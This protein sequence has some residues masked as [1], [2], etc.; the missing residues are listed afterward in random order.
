MVILKV[1]YGSGAELVAG[2]VYHYWQ[3]ERGAFWRL[4]EEADASDIPDA[5]AGG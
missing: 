3:D 5:V 4:E 1:V 2:P